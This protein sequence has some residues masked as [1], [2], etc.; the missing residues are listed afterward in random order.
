MKS[1]DEWINIVN[2]NKKLVDNGKW[3]NLIFTFGYGNNDY[4][5]EINNGRILSINRRDLQTKS[6]IFKIHADTKSWEKHW[7]TIPPRDYHD[8]FAMLAK[9]IVTIDGNLI[10]LMQNLQYFKD[11]IASNRQI[12]T[13]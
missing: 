8:I 6:G 12:K 11:I 13:N 1:I 10:P 9:K 5:F 7:L 3:L 2:S 4:L